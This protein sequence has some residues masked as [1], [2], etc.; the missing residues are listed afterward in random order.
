MCVCVYVCVCACVCMNGK[1]QVIILFRVN[2]REGARI[3]VD[4]DDRETYDLVLSGDY[5]PGKS[6]TKIISQ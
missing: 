4:E 5:I 2:L 1:E 6:V 3:L